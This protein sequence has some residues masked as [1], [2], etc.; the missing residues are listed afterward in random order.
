MADATIGVAIAL[1]LARFARNPA[2]YEF[3]ELGPLGAVTR[4]LVYLNPSHCD[5]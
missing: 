2:M 5:R 3:V 1:S 4:T